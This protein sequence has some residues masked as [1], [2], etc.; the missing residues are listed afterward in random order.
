M[1]CTQHYRINS[2]QHYMIY[3]TLC[4][5]LYTALYSCLYTKQYNRAGSSNIRVRGLLTQFPVEGPEKGSSIKQ[6]HINYQI[7]RISFTGQA[8]VHIQ[9][10][11]LQFFLGS[12]DVLN[13]KSKSK[14]MCAC[15]RK[16]TVKYC[17]I[18]KYLYMRKCRGCW[19]KYRMDNSLLCIH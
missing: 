19:N 10:I 1:H 3:T 16:H 8:C 11:G 4:I 13:R 18:S 5:R 14:N 9:G 15:V 12:L 17:M 2:A 6:S 7:R